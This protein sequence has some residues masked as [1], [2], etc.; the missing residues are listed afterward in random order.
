MTN[1]TRSH[2][3]AVLETRY[4]ARYCLLMRRLYGR[5]AAA[6]SFLE[7]F[8]GSAAFAG[9]LGG[10]QHVTAVAGAA[11]A[12]AAAFSIVFSPGEKRLQ[13][14]MQR[15][16]WNELNADAPSLAI[17]QL[18]FRIHKLRDEDVPDIQWLRLPAYNDTMRENGREDQIQ[19]LSRRE[20]MTAFFA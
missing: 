5:C 16:R 15:R 6:L 17:D 11:M 19:A 4:G 2:S 20:R 3:E 10:D 13:C 12:A 8:G 18:E 14:E 7:I 1:S 9:W